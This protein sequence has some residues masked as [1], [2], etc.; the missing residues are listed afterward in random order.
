MAIYTI[1]RRRWKDWKGVYE[2][3]GRQGNRTGKLVLCTT[4]VNIRHRDTEPRKRS[5]LVV[6]YYGRSRNHLAIR[7]LI[8]WIET[9]VP[10]GTAEDEDILYRE[11]KKLVQLLDPWNGPSHGRNGVR[12][13]DGRVCD[14]SIRWNPVVYHVVKIGIIPVS[15]RQSC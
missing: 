13:A 1:I 3:F 14:R 15:R 2:Q 7:I 8:R 6:Y 9:A 4:K 10:S 11:I 12:N 5:A